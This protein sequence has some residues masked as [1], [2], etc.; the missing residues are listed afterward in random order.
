MLGRVLG[1]IGWLGFLVLGGV[2]LAQA[3]RAPSALL[4]PPRADE[5][6]PCVLLNA[7]V[8]IADLATT[9]ALKDCDAQGATILFPDGSVGEVPPVGAVAGNN[10][11]DGEAA[12]VY[13]NWG[14]PGI[15]VVWA[16]GEGIFVYGTTPDA[17]RHELRAYAHSLETNS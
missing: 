5:L 2:M 7:R 14:V 9:E 8:P 17:A 6:Q 1:G 3:T 12:R 11:K 16:N 10:P 4:I 15:G 13:T